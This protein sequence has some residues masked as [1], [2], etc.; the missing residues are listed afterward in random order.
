M[1]RD[2]TFIISFKN[3]HI[4]EYIYIKSLTTNYFLN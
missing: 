4:Y 3:T 2:G 1:V